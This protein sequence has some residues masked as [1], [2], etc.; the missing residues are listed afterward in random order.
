MGLIIFKSLGMFRQLVFGYTEAARIMKLPRI[1][2]SPQFQDPEQDR[3][4]NL[5]HGFLWFALLITTAFAAAISI[6]F[7]ANI[8]RAFGIVGFIVFSTLICFPLI[9]RG[10]TRLASYSFGFLF[11]LVVTALY[12]TG[13]GAVA[14]D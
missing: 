13:G 8:P 9:Y 7:P 12:S 4:S 6:L 14:Y 3:Q 2:F 1:F 5:L 10:K 11:W